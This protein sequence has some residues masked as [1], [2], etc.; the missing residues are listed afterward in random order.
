MTWETIAQLIIAYGLP[1]AAAIV[2]K[3][4]SGAPPTPADFDELR[5]LAAN[6]ASDRAKAQLTK[7]GIPLDSKEAQE[8]LTLVQG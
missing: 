2:A 7:L 8:I 6:T 4:S 3:W 1:V 5:Q